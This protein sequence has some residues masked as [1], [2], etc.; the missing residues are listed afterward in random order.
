[1][2]LLTKQNSHNLGQCGRFFQVKSTYSI[3]WYDLNISWHFT[4]QVPPYYISLESCH[5]L[6]SNVIINVSKF[7]HI[8]SLYPLQAHIF[9]FN[10]SY[11]FP[12]QI[13]TLKMPLAI[14]RILSLDRLSTKFQTL[15]LMIYEI[16]NEL[17]AIFFSQNTV[18]LL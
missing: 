16:S 7:P 4:M 15:K 10:L 6:L 12:I 5:F 2:R 3:F 14:E 18:F 8:Q 1:M 11:L 9:L 17:F 13:L